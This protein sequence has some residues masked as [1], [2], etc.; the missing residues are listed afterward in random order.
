MLFRLLLPSV[1][2]HLDRVIY[3]DADVIVLH[4]IAELWSADLGGAPIGGV[5]DIGVYRK[6]VRE[7]ARGGRQFR[8][9]MLSLGMDLT[10]RQYVNSG[11]LLLDLQQLRANNFA[12]Q[13]RDQYTA[14]R[15]RLWYADQDIINVV[16]RDQIRHHRSALERPRSDAFA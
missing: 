12:V 15:D 16:M 4:D 10:R 6:L 14:R 1:L 2:G 8:D 7:D 11:L 9:H 5:T 13:V 3:M